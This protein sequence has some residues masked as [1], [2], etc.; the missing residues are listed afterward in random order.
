MYQKEEY[1]I[2]EQ[3]LLNNEVL[4]HLGIE[5]RFVLGCYEATQC[6]EDVDVLLV[7]FEHRHD[8][9][10]EL[11]EVLLIVVAA[12]VIEKVLIVVDGNSCLDLKG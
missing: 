9:A 2:Q 3:T 1:E 8:A 12:D 11:F 6:A 4:V 10:P 7:L 5:E